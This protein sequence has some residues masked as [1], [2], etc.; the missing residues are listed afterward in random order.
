MEQAASFPDREAL[1]D[2]DAAAGCP[3]PLGLTIGEY[4]A[5]DRSRSILNPSFFRRDEL[6]KHAEILVEKTE[7][8]AANWEERAIKGMV[9]DLEQDSTALSQSVLLQ[10]LFSLDERLWEYSRVQLT[11]VSLPVRMLEEA[12]AWKRLL[13]EQVAA[14]WTADRSLFR[15][16]KVSANV[17]TTETHMHTHTSTSTRAHTRAPC[18]RLCRHKLSRCMQTGIHQSKWPARSS[19]RK[20]P[21][22][23]SVH[24][25]HAARSGAVLAAAAAAAAT[26]G[27]TST[28]CTVIPS[29]TNPTS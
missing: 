15:F 20:V 6:A 25:A 22:T 17:C 14:M 28:T 21:P 18:M 23:D 27:T 19:P 16:V 5:W 3:A 4:E 1:S 13:Q 7:Q 24:T 9:I 29:S 8:M 2:E 11:P 26:A 12:L 10:M